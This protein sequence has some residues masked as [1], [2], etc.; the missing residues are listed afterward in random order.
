V[1]AF[2]AADAPAAA[3]VP[4]SPAPIDRPLTVLLAEDGPVNQLLVRRLLE[5][6][7]HTVTVVGTGAE[8]VAAVARTPYDAVL[9]DIQMP[10]MDG[11]EAT[12][13]IRA[14]EM[15]GQRHVPII[16]LSAHAME[17]VRERCLEVGMDGYL[18]KP[19]R[20]DALFASLAEHAGTQSESLSEPA[21][22]P[23]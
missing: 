22:D 17:G 20:A 11:F 1:L 14:H 10:D 23:A 2:C 15:S 13:M 5:K 9:M 7:G 19:I 18:S 8:A 21:G 12:V 6:A 4:A 16:A 3:P